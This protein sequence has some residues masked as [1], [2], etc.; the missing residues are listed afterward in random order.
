MDFP[1]SRR[2][3]LL[4]GL[5]FC[6]TALSFLDRQVLS[7]LAPTLIAEFDMSNTS[8]SRVVTAFVASYTVMFAVGGRVM[9]HLGTRI[10]L[11]VAVGVWSIASAAHALAT[12]PLGLGAARLLLGVGEGAC[13]PGVTKGA[14]EWM[15]PHRR[16]FAVGLANG[17]SAFGAVLAPPLTAWWAA[18]WGWRGAFVATALL[19]AAWLVAW[20][21]ATRGLPAAVAAPVAASPARFRDLLARPA[22]RR[23]VIA[24]FFFD[25]VFYLYMFWIPQYL[26][27]ERGMSLAQIGALTW[28]PFLAVGIST[29][30][31]GRL[32]DLLVDRG[33][34][35]R[36]ARLGWM[37]L[38]ALV[39]PVSWLVIVADGPGLAIALMSVLMFAHGFWIANFIT[40]VT[41]I[42]D[43]RA[44]AT[45]VGLTGMAG[46]IAGMLSNLATG[47]V[48]DAFG[49]AP[50]F[51]AA[52]VVYPIAWL[53]IASHRPV[54]VAGANGGLS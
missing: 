48:V 54:A 27:T 44:V 1:S 42:V 51:L 16:A 45:A 35:P 50:V 31:A 41:D 40:L 49:F 47:P 17:G 5:L 53:I 24:R 13:F 38:A 52:S 36:K 34:Q 21:M 2:G 29:I 37:L 12:G 30:L 26:A 14:I 28:I 39:T 46:G 23:M 20:V 10:G 18:T 3:W 19:G 8:Y 15:P 25:P 7:V 43:A 9:D 11:A 33:W 4:C 22:L 32:S 6:A